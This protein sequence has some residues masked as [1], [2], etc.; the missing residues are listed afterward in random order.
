MWIPRYQIIFQKIVDSWMDFA[1]RITN[2]FLPHYVSCVEAQNQM[3]RQQQQ[4]IGVMNP[5]LY[6]PNHPD[7]LDMYNAAMANVHMQKFPQ[8]TSLNGDDVHCCI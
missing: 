8:Q 5:A 1:E 2:P 3:I 4:A 6:D 7:T